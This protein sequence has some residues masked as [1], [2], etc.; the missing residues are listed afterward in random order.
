MKTDP[1][2]LFDTKAIW[3]QLGGGDVAIC[4][5]PDGENGPVLTMV[6]LCLQHQCCGRKDHFYMSPDNARQ[7]AAA[8][9]EAANDADKEKGKH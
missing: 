8:L 9:L 7:V 5:L 3:H 1:S 6:A 2:T 4:D